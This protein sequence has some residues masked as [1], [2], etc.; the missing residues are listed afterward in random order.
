MP[1]ERR[2]VA[3]LRSQG[4]GLACAGAVVV[5]LAIGSVVLTATAEGASANVQLDDVRAFF[6]PPSPWHLWL[7]L[8]LPV[9]ALYGLNT[10]LC[11]ADGVV[12]RWRCGQRKLAAYA[13]VLTHVGFLLALVAHGVGGLWSEE[14]PPVVVGPRWSTLGADGT[15]ARLAGVDEPVLPDGTPRQVSAHLELRDGARTWRETVEHNAPLT[16]GF[17]SHLLLLTRVVAAPAATVELAGARCVVVQGGPCALGDRQVTL[18]DVRPA[19]HWGNTPLAILVVTH[20]NGSRERVLGLAGQPQHLR[21]G[22]SLVVEDLAI[23]RLALLRGRRAPGNP[24]ALLAAVVL[25]A[26]LALM[27]RRWR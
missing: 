27:G 10:A 1:S 7:Y 8:L 25:F 6:D 20:A 12:R 2:V 21:D 3:A 19:G 4:L 22:T 15:E 13:T 26:G 18:M 16:R 9:L 17:G 14:L 5:L 23:E 11:V 24:V